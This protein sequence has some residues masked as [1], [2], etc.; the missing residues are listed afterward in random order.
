MVM[1]HAS[2]VERVRHT[3]VSEF[4]CDAIRTAVRHSIIE[5]DGQI[6]IHRVK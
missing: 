1:A 6:R 4:L 3:A 2:R 5:A